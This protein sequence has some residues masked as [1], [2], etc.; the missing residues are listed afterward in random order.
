MFEL[1]TLTMAFA[2]ERRLAEYVSRGEKKKETGPPYPW[3]NYPKFYKLVCPPPAAS[4]VLGP[5]LS[6]T[7]RFTSYIFISVCIC[8]ESQGENDGRGP[9]TGV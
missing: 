2:G 9:G 7:P 4:F 5:L 8:R 3:T 1:L 6:L